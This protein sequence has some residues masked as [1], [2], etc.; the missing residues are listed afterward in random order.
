MGKTDPYI[1]PVYSQI[2]RQAQVSCSKY[3]FKNVCLLGFDKHNNFT[4]SINSN[5][6]DFYDL[7]LKNWNINDEEWSIN[8]K[9]DLVICTRC[10]YFSKDP[11]K[12][13]KNCHNILD[14]NGIILVDWGL[15]DH[16]RYENYKIGWVKDDEHE[17]AYEKDN[18]VWS[19]IW[20]DSFLS[21]PSFQLFE[22]RVKKFGYNDIKAA[23]LNE[24]PSVYEVEN[25]SNRFNF[26]IYIETY[27]E[28]MPQIYFIFCGTKIN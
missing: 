21:H 25:E 27:W 5:N 22:N 2:L 10:P 9:Y 18:Y 11:S 4:R 23:M 3:V 1:L 17:S 19:T 12:F 20:N 26:K 28:G 16:W 14:S 13:F 8:K 15:G 24:V 7:S 6:F